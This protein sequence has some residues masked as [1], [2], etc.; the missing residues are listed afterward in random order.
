M[1]IHSSSL[2]SKWTVLLFISIT[3]SLGCKK[4]QPIVEKVQSSAYINALDYVTDKT[5]TT[6]VTVQLQAA[7]NATPVGGTLWIPAGRYKT[8]GGLTRTTAIT[9][10]G[11]NGN[12]TYNYTT[13]KNDSTGTIIYSTSATN[14]LL[15]INAAGCSFYDIA[16]VSQS[17][18]TP[19]SSVG[20]NLTNAGFFRSSNCAYVGFYNNVVVEDGAGWRMDNNLISS[21]INYGIKI[22]NTTC[23]DCGDWV[24]D[25]NWF[26]GVGTTETMIRHESSGGGK[27]VN[28]KINPAFGGSI[29]NGIDVFIKGSTSDDVI[30]NNSIEGFSGSAIK[31]RM[32]DNR[33]FS[34][35]QIFQNQIYTIGHIT[36]HAIDINGSGRLNSVQIEDNMM[37]DNSLNPN[38]AV[39]VD[40]TSTIQVLGNQF[41]GW[42]I[43]L[44]MVAATGVID[45]LTTPH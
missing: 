24:L 21:P 41:V 45:T 33:N 5:G 7:I 26:A 39:E 40:S 30:S 34:K 35:L 42:K 2:S 6:D 9:L 4:N 37:T 17:A 20:L 43:K 32:A 18:T 27:I 23:P 38:S 25:G 19:I 12:F 15:N 13:G 28:N 1:R 29:V 10:Q 44:R 22:N 36:G 3:I 11:D 31:V 16:F 8:S 14:N